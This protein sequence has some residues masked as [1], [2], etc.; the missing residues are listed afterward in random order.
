MATVN[1]VVLKHHKKEDNTWNVK[2]RVTLNRKSAY[3]NSGIYVSGRQINKK[4][5]ITDPFIREE[6]EIIL[7]AARKDI[8]A[9]RH[10]I[11]RFDAKQLASHIY[12]K[13]NQPQ[14]FDLDF[15]AFTTQH[16]QQIKQ[17]NRKGSARIFITVINSI[18]NFVGRPVLSIHDITPQFLVNYEAWL[19]KNNLTPNGINLYLRN[20]RTLFNLARAQHNDEETGTIN[21]PTYPFNKYRIPAPSQND[22]IA[23]LPAQI[24]AIRNSDPVNKRE[25]LARDVFMLSFYL[26]GINTIDLFTCKKTTGGRLHYNRQ[27]VASRRADNA[28]TS[29]KIQPEAMKL[30]HKYKDSTEKHVFD[31]HTR[32]A[33]PSTF[34]ANI[35]IGLKKIGQ[36]LGIQDLRTYHARHSWATIARNICAIPKE[37][38]AFALNHAAAD[39]TDTYIQKDYTIIDRANRK[40]L[41]TLYA[42]Q[43]NNMKISVESLTLN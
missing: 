3:F 39:V 41:D 31:F 12:N 35:N 30:L 21:I 14:L 26:A 40:V 10:N 25:V 36:A 34:N 20:I 5:K 7:S 2:I 4:Y 9:L 38:I 19:R 23:L 33:D 32:Y 24:A 1:Y 43:Q 11:A 37:D 27:K 28:F 18:A 13:I 22:S 8:I 16:A 42:G 15:I 17:Q 6:V 29:I